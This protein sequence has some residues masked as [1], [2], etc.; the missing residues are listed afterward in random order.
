MQKT[1]AKME[2][3]IFIA[4]I[5]M[6]S[7]GILGFYVKL[8]HGSPP[9]PVEIIHLP[10]ML[11]MTFVIILRLRETVFGVMS[12]MPYVLL[13][14]LALASFRW[15][16]NPAFTFREALISLIYVVYIGTMCWRYSWKDLI[17]GMWVAMFG[18][19]CLSVFLFFFV[20]SIGENAVP[21]AGALAGVWMEKNATGQAA[22]F[23]ACLALARFAISP[24]TF[25]TSGVSFI[26]FTAVLLL[27]TS[28]TSLVAY[29]VACVSFGWVFLMRRNIVTFMVTTWTS[30]FA[31]GLLVYFIKNN[32]ETVLGLLGRSST[33]TGRAE[34]WKSVEI[35][36]A[37]RPLLG[38]G[39]SGYWDL[40]VYGKTLAY[41]YQDLDYLPRHSHN[42]FI[43]MQLNLGLVGL[44]I[45]AGTLAIYLLISIFRIRNTHGAYFVLPFT[46]AAL[47]IG[48]FESVL[49]YPGNFA[50]AI[51]VLAAGKMVRPALA[52]ERSSGLWNTIRAIANRAS[53]RAHANAPLPG[54]N[55]PLPAIGPEVLAVDSAALAQAP[56]IQMP[57]WERRRVSIAPV[58]ERRRANR[59]PDQV[60]FVPNLNIVKRRAVRRIFGRKPIS[61]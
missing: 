16:L 50:G 24:K 21:H 20:P 22:T 35:S 49:A 5:C 43:E 3:A 46:L 32:T 44:S 2:Y 58:W 39:F 13:M 47:I 30:L 57:V 6:I 33:F 19:A 26:V 38:H 28:K 37:D 34:I 60:W 54:S 23:G 42:S 53:R 15:S 61:T 56:K 8:F 11:A 29:I 45:L 41:V 18:M 17:E 4:A 48:C 31:G 10:I 7:A 59:R 40:D 9:L 1:I 14:I 52:S 12:V 55:V 27:S 51:I 25:F 36:L